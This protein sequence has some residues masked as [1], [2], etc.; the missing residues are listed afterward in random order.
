[1]RRRPRVGDIVVIKT[2]QGAALAQYTHKHPEFGVL[3]RVLRAGA[4]VDTGAEPAALA[5]LPT[6]FATFF[7]LGAACAR[8]IA[9]ILGHAPIPDSD[10]AFPC[11]RQP[12]RVDP[13]QTGATNWLLWDGERE[14]IVPELNEEQRHYPIRAIMNDTLLVERALSGWSA[15]DVT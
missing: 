3:V 12:L 13:R 11:F 1:M 5:R 6:Q 7:P 10:R 15:A 4:M 14:W 2:D 8:G 9:E